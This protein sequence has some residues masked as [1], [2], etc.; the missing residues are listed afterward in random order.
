MLDVLG[1][2]A[3]LFHVGNTLVD[4]EGCIGVGLELGWVNETWGVTG[5]RLAFKQFMAALAEQDE[6]RLEIRQFR[7]SRPS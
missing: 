1:R 4:F 7:P 6:F 5:S 2:T 3:I